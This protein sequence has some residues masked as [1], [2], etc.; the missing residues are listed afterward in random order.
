M[1]G[2]IGSGL[3]IKHPFNSRFIFLYRG[4]PDPAAEI[5]RTA[6]LK[7]VIDKISGRVARDALQPHRAVC[8]GI[9]L[10]E[11]GLCT[12]RG[13]LCA[14]VRDARF[15]PRQTGWLFTYIGVCIILVQGGLIGRLTRR[16]GEMP[17]VVT[18]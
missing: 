13:I 16:F 11:F 10:P 4:L 3:S 12:G 8:A 7:A 1:P 17:I 5:K 15:C 9:F 6:H 2:G 14:I 18:G